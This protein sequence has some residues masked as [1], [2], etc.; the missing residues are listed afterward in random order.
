MSGLFFTPLAEADL[1]AILEYI[2]HDRPLTATAVVAR[3]REKSELLASQPLI[4]QRRPEFP[5]DYRSFPVERWVIFYRIVD[6][7]VE[8]HR[9][10]DGARDL[11][12]LIG[13]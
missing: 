13:S 6:D 2:A 1:N 4:G 10:V 5:G 9:V 8:I 12:S 3:I 11:D 7:N